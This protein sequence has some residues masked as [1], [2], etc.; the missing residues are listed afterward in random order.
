MNDDDEKERKIWLQVTIFCVL[1][2][3]HI[4]EEKK[5]SKEKIDNDDGNSKKD[6]E[7]GVH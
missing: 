2:L 1:F 3:V 6:E 7:E 5:K 4:N